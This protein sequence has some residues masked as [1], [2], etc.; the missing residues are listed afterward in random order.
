M[1]SSITHTTDKQIPRQQRFIIRTNVWTFIGVLVVLAILV[2]LTVSYG[3]VELRTRL[4]LSDI[5]IAQELCQKNI[6]S[7]LQYMKL[8]DYNKSRGEAR[9]YCVASASQ[10]SVELILNKR[11]N[12]Q[13]WQVI[14]VNYVNESKKLY[15]PV[16][17]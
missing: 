2:L 14:T 6:A 13:G 8:V 16:Y 1:I 12:S 3:I 7:E 5:E 17:T 11:D 4:F 15:W 10:D 9:L